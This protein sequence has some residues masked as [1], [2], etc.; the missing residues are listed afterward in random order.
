MTMNKSHNF[1]KVLSAGIAAL[2]ITFSVMAEQSLVNAKEIKRVNLS[3]AAGMEVVSTLTTYQPGAMLRRHYHHGVEA[4]LVVEGATV[5]APGKPPKKLET[6]FSLMNERD[7]PH[8]GFKVVGDT[9]L[10]LFTVHTVD[11]GKPLY[12]WV[13]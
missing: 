5:Q 6:G 9:P 8:G 10:T 7:V 3:G 12:E 1:F 2:F 13:E 11:K 4:A